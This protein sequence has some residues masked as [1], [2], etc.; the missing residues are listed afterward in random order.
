MLLNE[1][2]HVGL[3]DETF[4]ISDRGCIREG[5]CYMGQLSSVS[6]IKV[7]NWKEC[8]M[9][10]GVDYQCQIWTFLESTKMCTKISMKYVKMF[11]L[12][13]CV[14]GPKSC[15]GKSKLGKVE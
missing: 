8:Q 7:L 15:Y 9:H 5:I 11:H 10:C 2:F 14:S 3:S 1:S 12:V 4:V 13:G 6:S